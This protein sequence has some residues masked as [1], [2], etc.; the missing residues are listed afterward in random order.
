MLVLSR[1]L[2]E[3]IIIGNNITVTVTRIQGNRI[4]LGIDAPKDICIARKELIEG[5]NNVNLHQ[6]HR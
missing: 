5:C 1:K 6:S 3:Q 2:K 4:W